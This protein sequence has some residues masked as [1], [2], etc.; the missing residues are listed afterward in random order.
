MTT[1]FINRL[2][3]VSCHCQCRYIC[4]NTLRSQDLLGKNP[5]QDQILIRH[6]IFRLFG[7]KSLARIFHEYAG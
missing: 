3:W 2:E 4:R 5:D 1:D 6:S 7:V